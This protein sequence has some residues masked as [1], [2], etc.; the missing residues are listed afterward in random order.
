MA[1]RVES[2]KQ[3]LSLYLLPMFPSEGGRF[4]SLLLVPPLSLW[5]GSLLLSALPCLGFITKPQAWGVCLLLLHPYLSCVGSLP[6]G[7]VQV[8]SSSL[9]PSDSLL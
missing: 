7:P 1:P 3:A 8:T 5:Q 9:Q 2:H 4:L 6:S